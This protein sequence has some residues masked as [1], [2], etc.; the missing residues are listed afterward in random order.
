[1]DIYLP[2][3]LSSNMNDVC[4]ILNSEGFIVRVLGQKM[5]TNSNRRRQLR[6][7]LLN[8]SCVYKSVECMKK[9]NEERLKMTGMGRVL[10]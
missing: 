1:M 6:T 8:Y 5:L 7:I 2:P 3:L 9:I 10:R 4:K